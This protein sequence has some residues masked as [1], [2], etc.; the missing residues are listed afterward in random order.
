MDEDAWVDVAAPE[1]L[2][3]DSP[4]LVKLG[5]R[6]LAVLRTEDG[7]LFAIDNRCPHEGYPLVQGQVRGCTLTCAWH[8]FK[9]DLRDG[10]CLKGDEAVAV[11]PVRVHEG[12]VQ[13]D[14]RPPVEE[15][16]VDKGFAGLEQGLLERRMGQVA[17]QVVR[18][19]ELGVEAPRIAVE[20]A[21][22]DAQR[23]EWGSTHALPVAA[24]LLPLLPRYPGAEAA[25]PLVQAFDMASEN[26]VRR[27]VR[28]LAEAVDPGDDPVAAGVRLRELVER[29]EGAAAEALLRGALDKG[30]GRAE[31]EPWFFGPA[32]DHH[33][34]FG[35]PLIYQIKIFDL[36]EQVGWEHAAVLLPAHLHGIVSSTREDTL[37]RWRAFGQRLADVEPKFAAW[38]V[39]P[40][41][42]ERVADIDAD[43]R[44]AWWQAWVQ[45]DRDASFDAVVGALD[46]AVAPAAIADLIAAAA[47]ARLLRFDLR[48]DRDI[49]VQEGWLDI[50]HS[51]SFADAVHH[52]VLRYPDATALRPL[53]YAARFVNNASGLDEPGPSSEP[54]P[55]AGK[56]DVGMIGDAIAQREPERAM[57][58]TAAY[59]QDRGADDALEVAL[60]ELP[61]ADLYVR[62]IIVAHVIKMARVALSLAA[63]LQGSPWAHAPILAFVRFAAAPLRERSLGR[64]VHEAKRLVVDGKVPR[65][66]T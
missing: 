62:P 5:K 59:L 17:R 29:E 54:V 27:S 38:R 53:F 7:D 32:C 45:G 34:S 49:T 20:A 28:P 36:L 61:F 44:Q 52:A 22:F 30:W 12:R 8:N 60:T 42:H 21:R 4:S 63:R 33:L 23:A 26:H 56:V 64:L 51:M 31:L 2:T 37:P 47:A 58:H 46:A 65:A 35:H 19:L 55:T 16:A 1:E 40:A 18:L 43:V 14:A 3:V 66:L 57:A 9:F 15:G 50:T 39:Q 11:Y 10:R 6:Q 41:R 48:H 24:D 13:V 25:L